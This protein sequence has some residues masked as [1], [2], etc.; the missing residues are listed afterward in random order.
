M[1]DTTSS[2]IKVDAVVFGKL[3]NLAVLGKIGFR[4]VLHVVIEGEDGLLSVEDL[5]A[6]ERE[7]SVKPRCLASHAI[8]RRGACSG[9]NSLGNDRAG[10]IVCHSAP[11]IRSASDTRYIL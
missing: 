9:E 10:I 11:A 2:G 1:T 7:E 4:L 5:G 3:F 6:L 8:K